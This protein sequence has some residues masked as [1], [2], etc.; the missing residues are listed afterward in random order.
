MGKVG[1]GGQGEAGH[2]TSISALFVGLV[3]LASRY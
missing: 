1:V 2:K 3:N